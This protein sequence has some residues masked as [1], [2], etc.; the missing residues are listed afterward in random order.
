MASY[1]V[2]KKWPAKTT[3]YDRYD[4]IRGA[5][6]QR[7]S[8]ANQVMGHRAVSKSKLKNHM[9]LGKIVGT[10]YGKAAN[11]SQLESSEL[12]APGQGTG[13][14]KGKLRAERNKEVEDHSMPIKNHAESE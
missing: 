11:S 8:L 3:S 6:N 2:N 13:Q 4:F 14:I 7:L 5:P 10:F 12:L 1:A 9:N